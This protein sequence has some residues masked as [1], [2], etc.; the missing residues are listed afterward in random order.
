V[1]ITQYLRVLRQQWF[2]VVLLA[3]LSVG[4][5][6][7]YTFRQTPTYAATTQ[8][9]VSVHSTEMADISQLNQGNAFIQQ[10]VKSYADIV[11]RPSSV[12]PLP[13]RP[14]AVRSPSTA[15]STPCC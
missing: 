2:V 4:G 6:S 1:T 14:W 5:A 3:A 8:L 11:S 7:A 9:F 12:W 15:R 13:P 10:R